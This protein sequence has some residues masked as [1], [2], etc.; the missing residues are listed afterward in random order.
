MEKEA[1]RAIPKLTIHRRY[2]AS[3]F[4]RVRNADTLHVL[5]PHI[6]NSGYER[7]VFGRLPDRKVSWD[8][9][10]RLVAK[11]FLGDPTGLEVN[12]LDGIKTNNRL[13]N[14]EICTRSENRKHAFRELGRKS[15]NIMFT[16]KQ[17]CKIRAEI[18]VGNQTQA[19]VARKYGASPMLISRM[20]RFIQ[21]EYQCICK[22]CI[23][24]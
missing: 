8:H 21:Y 14:L 11:A 22:K 16:P 9:V 10:H 13:D 17:A 23:R 15:H 19:A 24:S 20:K 3:N 18:R 4:G 12:H 7:L 6:T 1:W 2:E 5:S